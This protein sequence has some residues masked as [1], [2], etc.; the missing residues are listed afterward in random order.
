MLWVLLAKHVSNPGSVM[1]KRTPHFTYDVSGRVRDGWG[2][3]WVAVVP[4]YY[5]RG[6]AVPT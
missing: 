1:K 5:A 3:G 4:P 6:C 2:E